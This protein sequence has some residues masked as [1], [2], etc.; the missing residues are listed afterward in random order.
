VTPTPSLST[1]TESS[2]YEKTVTET[3]TQELELNFH[4]RKVKTKI[5][6]TEVKVLTTTETRTSILTLS[7]TPTWSTYTETI[8][9]TNSEILPFPSQ[10]IVFEDYNQPIRGG[11]FNQP[12]RGL[13][14]SAVKKPRH[15]G[16]QGIR[17]EVVEIPESLDSFQSLQ[18]ILGRLKKTFSRPEVVSAPASQPSPT[19]SVMTVFLSGSKP[20]EYT[21][22]LRT[23]TLT[24]AAERR[25]RKRQI[26]PH[27]AVPQPIQQTAI[28][29]PGQNFEDPFSSLSSVLDLDLDLGIDLQGSIASVTE[30][31]RAQSTQSLHGTAHCSVVTV[32]VTVTD[33]S[34]NP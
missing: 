31:P 15:F 27:P 34:C 1:V 16:F 3:V 2:S 7:P 22:S 26:A 25:R 13:A 29:E 6:E 9:Q 30:S 23:I 11:A 33:D 14:P 28:Y 17:A 18:E 21:T 32:T 10:P 19:T 5:F 12:I 20:G 24:T 8:T 4:G